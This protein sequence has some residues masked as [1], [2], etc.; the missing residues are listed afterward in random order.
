MTSNNL[1]VVKTV[2][3]ISREDFEKLT[4][5]SM[6]QDLPQPPPPPPPSL[7][8]SSMPNRGRGRKHEVYLRLVTKVHS[9]EKIS[10]SCFALFSRFQG[11]IQ[12]QRLRQTI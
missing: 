10:W 11:S 8:V 2:N 7:K 9:G 5:K 3:L 4:P 12:S 1:S 6:K